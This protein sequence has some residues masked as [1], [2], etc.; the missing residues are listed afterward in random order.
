VSEFNDNL[1]SVNLQLGIRVFFFF[2]ELIMIDGNLGF[3]KAVGG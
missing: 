3:D 2:W 1:F